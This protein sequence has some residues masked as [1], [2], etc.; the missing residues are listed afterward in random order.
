MSISFMATKI[1]KNTE[2]THLPNKE[3][4]LSTADTRKKAV[5]IADDTKENQHY[6]YQTA[7]A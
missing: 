2:K 7:A 4:S 3:I 6:F 5:D 1:E